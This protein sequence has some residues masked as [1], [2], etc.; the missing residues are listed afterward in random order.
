MV[1]EV[2]TSQ[3]LYVLEKDV[4]WSENVRCEIDPY[5]EQRKRDIKA[6]NVEAAAVR[7]IDTRLSAARI[8]YEALDSMTRNNE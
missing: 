2:Q 3:S 8:Q 4:R 5:G 1:A 6:T 7:D